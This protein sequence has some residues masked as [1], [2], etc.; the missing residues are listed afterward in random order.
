MTTKT[1]KTKPAAKPAAE[2]AK[3][4]PAKPEAK[5][6]PAA[7]AEAPAPI[8]RP[9]AFAAAFAAA[10]TMSKA[11]ALDTRWHAKALR[12]ALRSQGVRDEWATLPHLDEVVGL[13]ADAAFA[14][15]E[16]K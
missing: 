16:A 4:K 12:V 5:A 3:P 6:K 14:A 2:P 1:T 9:V 7:K 13:P 15:Y 10:A 8:D 11:L